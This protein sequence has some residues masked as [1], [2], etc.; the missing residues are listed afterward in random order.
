MDNPLPNYDWTVH[1]KYPKQHVTCIND[2]DF[3]AHSMFSGAL[4]AMI[5][6]DPCPICGQYELKASRSEPEFIS[7]RG[8]L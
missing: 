1:D 2:H 4:I 7:I 3:A 5:S 6:R 8:R